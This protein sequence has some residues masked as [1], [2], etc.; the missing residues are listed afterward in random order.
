M[1]WRL[2]I[3]S[4]LWYGIAMTMLILRLISRTLVLKSPKR[5]QADDWI[6]VFVVCTYT[7]LIVCINYAATASTNLLPPGF[8][9]GSLT[10][11]DIR[12]RIWGSK[13]V[14][15][16]EQC[17]CITVWL[18]KASLLTTYSRL[19][20]GRREH[21]AVKILAGYVA[22]S[23]V[24]MEIFYLGIWCRPFTEYWA[25]PTLNIQCSAAI[26]HLITNAV[27]NL[28]SDVI[29]LSIALPMFVRSKLPTRK[30]VALICIFGLGFFVLVAAVLNKY[31]SF[32]EP[33]GDAW[34][35]WYVRESS[36]A[37]LVANVP[38]IWTL[39]RR[40]FKLRSLDGTSMH[41]SRFGTT[42][43]RRGSEKTQ[44]SRRI[45]D[46][47]LAGSISEPN[48]SYSDAATTAAESQQRMVVRARDSRDPDFIS[49]PGGSS[50]GTSNR[51]SAYSSLHE[52]PQPPALAPWDGAAE[53]TM[54]KVLLRSSFS[55]GGGLESH[56]YGNR[57]DSIIRGP[58]L[59][60]L[61]APAAS[62]PSGYATPE[63]VRTG[64]WRGW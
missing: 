20:V 63:R 10:Q 7:T 29:L 57:Y 49:E 19:T 61:R 34:T 47:E 60:E 53:Q 52:T 50:V 16:V 24:F 21:F 56:D 44:H 45:V 31:Y 28:S 14:L 41:G 58:S 33:F 48:G 36:T 37:V 11:E 18:V 39:L 8:D 27:F 17:Q 46:P 42:V 55:R 38:F 54:E 59:S 3:E 40:I 43:P 2:D 25:V 51:Q 35:F 9:T 32:T 12:Q 15:V 64:S 26:N 6:M 13:L 4:W 62:R 22:F 30:K 5:W 1:A 23:F